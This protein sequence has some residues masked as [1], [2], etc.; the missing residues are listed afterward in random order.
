MIK[1]EKL[2]I[3]PVKSLAGFAVKSAKLTAFGLEND[4]RYVIIDE[5][6]QFLSQRTLPI[7]ATIKTSFAK[8]QLV[9]SHNDSSIKVPATC[10]YGST[11]KVKIWQDFVY[12]KHMSL[13]VDKWLSAILKQKCHL[14]Y[15]TEDARRQVDKDY[16]PKN[17]F[18]SFADGF[19]LLLTSLASHEEL[20]KRLGQAV[21]IKRFRPN[22]VI[23][24][25][26]PF[27]EDDL[28]EFKIKD[29]TFKAVK[30]CSRCIMPS[31]NQKTGEKD[32]PEILAELNKFRKI[33][34]KIMF[35]QNVIFDAIAL[36]RK[37]EFHLSCGDELVQF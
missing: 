1:I 10:E 7:M 34:N 3:Y 15:M 20:N 27:A 21:S 4:R 2:F 19:P 9:L 28:G 18:V 11:K 5:N 35:G 25:V 30:Q 33:N 16:A 14:L 23:S 36:F 37:K 29:L 6:N 12:A 8:N 22:I 31:I 24:G 32:K 26:K 17:Q 13:L